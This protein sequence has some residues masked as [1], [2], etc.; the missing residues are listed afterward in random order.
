MDPL[1]SIPNSVVK[2][3]SGNDTFGVAH[4]NNSSMP[5]LIFQLKAF[6]L[7]DKRKA[8]NMYIRYVKK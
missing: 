1:R 8:F 6:L 5:E 4:W 7:A 2:H 3:D